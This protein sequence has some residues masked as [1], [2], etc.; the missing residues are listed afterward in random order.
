MGGR[1]AA[2]EQAEAHE[3][4]LARRNFE[5]PGVHLHRWPDTPEA[6]FIKSVENL[7]LHTATTTETLN[8]N[9]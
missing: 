8:P 3:A 2:G 4:S 5:A 7:I 1:G 9:P 6:T